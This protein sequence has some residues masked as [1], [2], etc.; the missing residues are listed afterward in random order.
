MPTRQIVWLPKALRD[1][2]RLRSFLKDK[3][4]IA[5]RKAVDVIKNGVKELNKNPKIG[6]PVSVEEGDDPELT[7]FRDLYIKFGNGNYVIRYRVDEEE[8]I[9]SSTIVVIAQLWHS[10]EDR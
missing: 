4:P 3:N 6:L 1:L 9:I 5:A 8:E 10:K 2:E 7:W